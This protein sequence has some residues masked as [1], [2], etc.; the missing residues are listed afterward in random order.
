M[1]MIERASPNFNARAGNAKPSHLI[2]HY[3]EMTL[4]SALARLCDPAAKVSCHY[5]ISEAGEIYR[6]VDEADRAWH[7][8]QAYWLG[9]TDLNTHSIGIELDYP[10]HSLRRPEGGPPDFPA[11]QM[12]ALRDL[13]R[14]ILSRHDIPPAHI[15]GHSDI[16]P[17]RKID[18]GETFDWRWLGHEG[19]GLWPEAGDRADGGDP[20]ALLTRY[21]YD[22]AVD[23]GTIITAF[24]RHFHPEIFRTPEKIGMPDPETLARLNSLL[25][26]EKVSC[27]KSVNGP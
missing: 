2:L 7:A 23:L 4:D 18:P 22:P 17:G 21:G 9:E 5:L 19:I 11:R 25:N 10:G 12:A 15:L 6:L 26:V 16:A 20:R 24:Q 14:D 8:G 1:N 13:C 27:N 3:T